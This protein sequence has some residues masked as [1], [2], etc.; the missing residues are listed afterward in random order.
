MGCFYVGFDYKNRVNGY[1][2]IGESG[3]KTPAQRL[4]TI[5]Q[6]TVLNVLDICFQKMTQNPKDFLLKVTSE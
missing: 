2:K 3:K 5:R 4:F 1:L 6:T